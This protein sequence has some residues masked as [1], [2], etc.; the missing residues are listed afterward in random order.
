MNGR[1]FA[2]AQVSATIAT[3]AEKFQRS[4]PKEVV[5]VNDAILGMNA[6][7]EAEEEA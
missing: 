1:F 5:V 6:V 3:G 7:K 4:N 2:S